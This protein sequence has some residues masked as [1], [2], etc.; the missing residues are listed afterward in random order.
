MDLMSLLPMLKNLSPLLQN[1]NIQNNTQPNINLENKNFNTNNENTYKSSISSLG[2]PEFLIDGKPNRI[3]QENN[4][5]NL[6]AS[7]EISLNNLEKEVNKSDTLN[8]N[9][10]KQNKSDI[11]KNNDIFSNT[12]S[13]NSNLQSLLGLLNNSNQNQLS[14]ILNLIGNFS[15]KDNKNSANSLFSLF[16]KPQEKTHNTLQNLK[17]NKQQNNPSDNVKIKKIKDFKLV[18]DIDF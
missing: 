6:H 9:L 15:S 4:T 12:I 13:N 5:N 10:T 3:N 14:S 18:N 7:N 8:T 16:N 17:E 11:C 1:F 2:Y